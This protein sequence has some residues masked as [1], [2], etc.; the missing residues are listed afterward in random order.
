M[1]QANK[2][3]G[4]AAASDASDVLRDGRTGSESKSAG[5]SALSQADRRTNKSTSEGAAES[6]SD[7]LHSDSTGH[8][9]KSAAGSALSQKEGNSSS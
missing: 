9:S 6:A 5:G 2:H 1:S 3:T 7:V 8:K 4:K